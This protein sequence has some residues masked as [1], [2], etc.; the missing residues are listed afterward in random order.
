MINNY[1]MLSI[2]L[3][4]NVERKMSVDYVILLFLTGVARMTEFR[5]LRH[6][7]QR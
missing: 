1:T 4:R 7:N 3:M 5:G 2:E 6:L